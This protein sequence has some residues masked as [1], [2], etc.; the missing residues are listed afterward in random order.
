[1]NFYLY[2]YAICISVA[3]NVAS[4]ILNNDQEM[5]NKYLDFLKVGSDKTPKEAF[6]VL[7]IDL[8]DRK[9]YENAISYFDSLVEKY[10]EI[11]NEK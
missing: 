9:V 11:F 8:E 1:M 3:C 2:S 10:N 6:D 5:L 4:K 7:E